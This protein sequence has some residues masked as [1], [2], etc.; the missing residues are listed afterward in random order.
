LK[1]RSGFTVTEGC[2]SSVACSFGCPALQPQG[3][4]LSGIPA[5]IRPSSATFRVEIRGLVRSRVVKK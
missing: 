5:L 3:A 4:M 1:S 2:E